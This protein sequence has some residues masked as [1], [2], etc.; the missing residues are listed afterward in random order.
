LTFYKTY[1]NMYSSD[2]AK[3]RTL[4]ELTHHIKTKQAKARFALMFLAP[5]TIFFCGYSLTVFKYGS[6]R[7]SKINRTWH[8]K[9]ISSTYLKR[10]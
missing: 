3:T 5:D 7:C 4:L 2:R 6:V 9:C 1:A 8:F 10:Q